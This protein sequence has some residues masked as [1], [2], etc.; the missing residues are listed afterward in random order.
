MAKEE[1]I[2]THGHHDAVLKSHSWR[3]AKN[4]AGFLL[5]YIKKESTILD[6]GCGPGTITAD[7]ARL[8]ETGQVI[9]LDAVS[10]VLSKA[11]DYANAQGITNV[12]FESGDGN[13]LHYPDNSFDIAFAHQV[14][15]HVKDPIAILK[16]MR[17][18]VKPGGIVAARDA[19]YGAFVWYP[20]LD[21]L[22]K[23]GDL[24]Q[25][26]AKGNGGE[27][28]AG[29]YLQFWAHQ[30]GF[31]ASEVDFTWTTWCHSTVDGGAQWWGE[32][33]QDRA[34]N[35]AFADSAISQG[36]AT[37]DDL[38]EIRK[39]WAEFCNNESAS[40]AVPSSEILCHV[41]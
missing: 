24:Y 39:A 35:T 29:R 28:N 16:E 5:P 12:T 3:T 8:A 25:K 6:L 17:R 41:L 31:K 36:F 38:E 22:T 33:W 10:D 27:P 13:S 21:G 40:I 15:Q 23:W 19:D 26:V 1:A 7:F 20:E 32:T 4:S 2:Y 34:T 30:A 14:L 9:G 11:R 37:K 18:V